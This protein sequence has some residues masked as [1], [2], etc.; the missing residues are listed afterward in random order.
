[1]NLLEEEIKSKRKHFEELNELKKTK[2]Y[3]SRKEIERMNEI[4][5]NTNQI[6]EKKEKENKKEEEKIEEEIIL[7]ENEIIKRL[8]VMNEPILYMNFFI[9]L[10][11]LVKIKM[12]E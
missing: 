6:E 3:L 9:F 11:Y 8:R 10:D 1:M 2:K 4:S 12:I 5:I 7:P